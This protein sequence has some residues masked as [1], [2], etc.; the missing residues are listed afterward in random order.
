M[1]FTTESPVWEGVATTG[2]P[3]CGVFVTTDSPA[4]GGVVT[5]GFPISGVVVTTGC[6]VWRVVFTTGGSMYV[7]CRGFITK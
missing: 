6:P 2:S 7:G 1:V 3:V 4:W 5:T